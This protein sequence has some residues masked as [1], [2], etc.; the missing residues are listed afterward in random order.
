MSRYADLARIVGLPG[1]TDA[2]LVL[3]YEDAIRHLDRMMDIPLSL[4][5]Y[6]VPEALY[7]ERR[8]PSLIMPSWTPAPRKTRGKWMMKPWAASWNALTTENQSHSENIST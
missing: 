8:T 5:D 4:K 3:S 1:H 2:Q 7:L 6:G